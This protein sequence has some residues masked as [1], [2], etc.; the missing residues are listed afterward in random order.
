MFGLLNSESKTIAGAAM[1]VGVLSLLSRVV[2]FI[3]DRILAGEFGAGD[4][5][6]IYYAA[7]R[8]PDALFT[9][10]VVGALSASFIPLFTKHFH[11]VAGKTDAWKLTNNTL[12][13][14]GTAMALVSIILFVFA[15]PLSELVAPGFNTLKQRSVADFTRVMLLAELLLMGSVV[16]GS[17]LQGLRRFFLYALAPIFYNIGI[18]VGALWL[19][20]ILGPIGLAWGVVL[21][22]FLHLLVQLYGVLEAGYQYRWTFDWKNRDVREVIA[23]MGPRVLGLAVSQINVILMTIIASG[24]AVGSVTVLTFAFN[25]QFLPIGIVGVSFA[26]AAFPIL[27]EHAE[28]KETERFISTFSLSVRQILFFIV[29]LTL[30]FLILRAQIVRVVVGAGKFGWEETILTADTLAFFTLSFFAQAL[31]FLFARAYF[32]LHDTM[33]PLVAGLVAATVNLLGSLYFS[34][35]AGV[36]GLALAFS[37]SSIVNLILLWVPLRNRLGSLGELSIV[38]SLYVFTSAGL[39]SG[40][41]MQLLKPVVVSVIS[42]DTFFGVLSQGLIAGGAGLVAYGAI[43]AS[44]RNREM[45][46]FSVSVRRRLF[47]KYQPEETVQTETTTGA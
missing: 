12:N 40:A 25:I 34:R 9:L 3:R 22:A 42:L 2:G 29:P 41:V 37:I 17:V 13:I 36:V 28:R 33:T 44:L 15:D 30:L 10:L 31:V 39:V 32:A 5:L 24:L 43:C 46:D 4:T 21:G 38:Q 27:C 19:S 16:F 20:D 23:L 47:K 26:V 8:V 18:I 1:L 45:L 14:L 35:E 6:D 11:R 7:F